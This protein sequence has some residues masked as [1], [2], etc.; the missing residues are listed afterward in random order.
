MEEDDILHNLRRKRGRERANATCFTTTLEGFDSSTPLD[1]LEHYRGRLQETLERL[2]SLDDAIHDLL[3]D[4]EHE[5]YIGICEE[6]TSE[7][8]KKCQICNYHGVPVHVT[9]AAPS[10][11]CG[12]YLF[13]ESMV[14]QRS[15]RSHQGCRTENYQ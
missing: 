9:L 15:D 5:E 11:H 3:P 2:L 6:Q 1:D 13:E 7:R 8:G 4:K 14:P 10:G 12:L